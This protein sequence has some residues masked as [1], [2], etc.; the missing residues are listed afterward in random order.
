MAVQSGL[1]G[2]V[3]PESPRPGSGDRKVRTGQQPSEHDFHAPTND[4]A[5]TGS[6]ASIRAVAMRQKQQSVAKPP[7]TLPWSRA[8][9]AIIHAGLCR[10]PRSRLDSAVGATLVSASG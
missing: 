10:V 1:P 4:R 8:N 5:P 9:L 7:A 3:L 6:T 2:C